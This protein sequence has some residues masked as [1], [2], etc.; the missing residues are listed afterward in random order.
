MKWVCHSILFENL[1]FKYSLYVDD[2]LMLC[3]N[4]Q[5]YTTERHAHQ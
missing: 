3:L 4:S 5:Y 2:F 1:D